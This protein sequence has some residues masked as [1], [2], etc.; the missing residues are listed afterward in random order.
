MP[1]DPETRA[2]IDERIRQTEARALEN[3]AARNAA[4]LAAAEQIRQIWQRVGQHPPAPWAIEGNADPI[5]AGKFH[6]AGALQAHVTRGDYNPGPPAA[7]SLTDPGPALEAAAAS[8][9]IQRRSLYAVLASGPTTITVTIAAAP[10]HP[11]A[12]YTTPALPPIPL[13]AGDSIQFHAAAHRTLYILEYVA[14]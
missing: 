5:P 1:V 10:M 7:I 2:Y 3:A 8:V 13:D 4:D 12:A 6:A 9:N 11:S 14:R